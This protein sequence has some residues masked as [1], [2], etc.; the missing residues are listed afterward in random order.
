MF[1]CL[2]AGSN[3]ISST[4]PCQRCPP[5]ACTHTL[6]HSVSH[7]Y[8]HTHAFS[9]PTTPFLSVYVSFSHTCS[10]TQTT[11]YNM[12]HIINLTL[13]FHTE[14]KQT[15]PCE[16]MEPKLPC[17]LLHIR[18]SI[19]DGDE[20][21]ILSSFL[22][23][24]LVFWQ[25]SALPSFFLFNKNPGLGIHL[26]LAHLMNSS[27]VSA[28]IFGLVLVPYPFKFNN[29]I[30]YYHLGMRQTFN[31]ACVK[32]AASVYAYSVCGNLGMRGR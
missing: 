28:N 12:Q 10:Q 29:V 4:V 26:Y 19:Y 18:R 21:E 30:F 9:L 14:D 22:G 5:P 23:G 15:L 13:S 27:S 20:R 2:T 6:S 17:Q 1:G 11:L 8:T 25:Q 16:G 3:Y 32:M 7:T 24:F 31:S